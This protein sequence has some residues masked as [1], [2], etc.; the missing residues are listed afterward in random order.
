MG[1]VAVLLTL[2]DLP[3]ALGEARY[4]HVLSK[5]RPLRWDVPSG[6]GSFMGGRQSGESREGRVGQRPAPLARQLGWEPAPGAMQGGMLCYA[7]LSK[8]VRGRVSVECCA[9][10]S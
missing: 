1:R 10:H 5:A 8:E 6:P 2:Q 9:M 7:E 4:K 3:R